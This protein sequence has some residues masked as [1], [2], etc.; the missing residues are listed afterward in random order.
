LIFERNNF[1]A[2]KVGI[3]PLKH[4]ENQFTKNSHFTSIPFSEFTKNSQDSWNYLSFRN[5]QGMT[6]AVS[7]SKQDFFFLL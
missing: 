2:A 5:L 1:V 3:P 6:D 4:Q 7:I